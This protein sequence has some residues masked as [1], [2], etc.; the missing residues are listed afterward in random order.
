[1]FDAYG[2]PVGS[3]GQSDEDLQL[4]EPEGLLALLDLKGVGRKAA[5]RA[6]LSHQLPSQ[7][8]PAEWPQ[9]VENAADKIAEW[10]S[11]GIHTVG[12]FDAR[13]PDQLRS[14]DD[15][16][17]ML[18][19]RGSVEAL[20]ERGVTVVGTRTPTKTGETAARTVTSHLVAAGWVVISGLAKGVD[21]AAHSEAIRAGGRTVA[22][23]AGGLD[24]IYPAENKPLSNQILETGGSLVAEVPPERRPA[25]GQFIERDRLQ[26]GLARAVFICQTGESGGSLHTARFAI[27]QGRP[28]FV[29]RP[30]APVAD[31]SKGLLLLLECKG[32]ELPQVLRE[33]SNDSRLLRYLTAAPV[34]R[35]FAREDIAGL[36]S[37]LT[38]SQDFEPLLERDEMHY[39]EIA[40]LELPV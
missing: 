15:P 11:R 19:I 27:A 33:W 7:V 38:E 31:K 12:F 17:A 22:V 4:H 9:H 3:R 39:R 2:P 20:Q 40:P 36:I 6:A 34:A 35:G 30:R 29:P 24:S 25:P 26:S 5:L 1:M 21:T 32:K 8:P 14:I 37:D 10:G 18:W 23:M 16:P 13:Y 28:L